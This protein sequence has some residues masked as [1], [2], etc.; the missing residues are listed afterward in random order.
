MSTYTVSP[1]RQ[2]RALLNRGLAVRI[3]NLDR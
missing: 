3:P 2:R 1:L